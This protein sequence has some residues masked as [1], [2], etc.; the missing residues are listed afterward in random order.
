MAIDGTNPGADV[1]AILART[2]NAR[3]GR[4]QSTDL[5][6]FEPLSAVEDEP[7]VLLGRVSC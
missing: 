3:M 2:A 1:G 6:V 7:N 4:L 5:E